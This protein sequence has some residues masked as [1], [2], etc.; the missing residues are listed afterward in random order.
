[1]RFYLDED[2]PDRVADIA[3]RRGIDTLST[4]EC[5][6]KGRSDEDQLQFAAEQ[7]RALV[8]RNYGDFDALT[9][10]LLAEG[11]SHAGVLLVS[12]S[13]RGQG[14]AAIASALARYDAEHPTGMPQYRIDYL[15]PVRG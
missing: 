13:L 1:M 15:V 2:I 4:Q 9:M 12:V 7:E 6:R 8:T 10:R 5:G 11:R 14:Y 3:R